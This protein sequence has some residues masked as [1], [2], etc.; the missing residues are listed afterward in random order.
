MVPDGAR[1]DFVV[2]GGGTAGNVVAGRLAENPNVNVLVVE[3]GVGNPWELDGV[4]TP[5]TAMEL[6]H[7][8]Y[9]WDY[10]AKFVDRGVWQRI[11]KNE[12]RGKILGAAPRP[13]TS[14]GFPAASRPTTGGRNT[15]ARN[16][17]GSRFFPTSARAR[18]ITTTTGHSRP[19]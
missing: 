7:S 10:L 14:A 3:A 2:V 4:N 6:R 18:P 11:D 9:D 1:F 13:T 16:G 15:V 8:P 12:T 19:T 17:P 5:G